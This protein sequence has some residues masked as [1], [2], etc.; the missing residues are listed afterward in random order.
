M[1]RLFVINSNHMFVI[2]KYEAAYQ[3]SG[4]ILLINKYIKR[5]V[6]T[7]IKVLG[8][9]DKL[10]RLHVNSTFVYYQVNSFALNVD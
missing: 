8:K 5:D 3:N 9:H 4:I 2:Q 1:I 10:Y 6:F 7:I